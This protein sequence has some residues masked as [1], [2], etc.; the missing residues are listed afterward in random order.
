MSQENVEIVRELWDAYSRG[1][2]DRVIALSDPYVVLVTLEEGPLYGPDAV[3][4]NYARWM[5]AWREEPETTVEEV[6]GSGDHV[7]VIACFRGRG[8][9]SGVR[10][11]QRLYEVYTLRNGKVLRVDEF[12]DRDQALE[13]VGLLE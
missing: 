13:A 11:A 7:I 6:I 3:R 2:I 9:G 10:V 8:R 5:E 4:A 1:N 12:S